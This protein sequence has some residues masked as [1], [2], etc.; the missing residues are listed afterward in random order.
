MWSKVAKLA[1]PAP[2][3]TASSTRP[4][5]SS[6]ASAFVRLVEQLRTLLSS[7]A[8]DARP[9]QGQESAARLLGE[10][11]RTLKAEQGSASS[12]SP[13][14]T[15]TE[16][17]LEEQVF[18]ELVGLVADGEKQGA[19]EELVKWYGRAIVDLEEGWLSHSAVNKPLVKLLRACVNEEGGLMRQ[20]E[21]AVVE[22]MCIVAERIKTRPELLAIFF[23]EKPGSRRQKDLS[24]S[25]AAAMSRPV[26]LTTLSSADENGR[27]SSPTLSQ[28]SASEASTSFAPS[29]TSSAASPRRRSDH[30]FLLFS[31]L[32]RFIH[33]EGEV[34]DYAREG[35]LSLVDVAFGYPALHTPS[36]A[37]PRTTSSSIVSPSSTV[38][39][40]PTSTTAAREAVLAFAEYL[41]DSDFA[42]VLG[43]G[44]G[45]LYGLLPSKLF[46]RT[47]S[48]TAGSAALQDGAGV[49]PVTAAGGMVLGGM[50]ALHSEEGDAEELERQREEEEDRLRAEGYGISGTSEVRDGL[51]GFLKLVEFAQDVLHRSTDGALLAGTGEKHGD[52]HIGEVDEEDDVRQQKLVLNTLTTAVLGA[53]RTLF[54]QNVLYP[55]IL[56]CSETDG[57][58]VAVLS[59]LDA[60][61]EVVQEGTKLEGAVLGFLMAEDEPDL[62]GAGRPP[63]PRQRP[64]NVSTSSTPSAAFLAPQPTASHVKRRKSSALLLIERTAPSSSFH[65]VDPYFA[66]TADGR[67]S[68]R[69]LLLSHVHS[70][71]PSTAAAALKLLQTMLAKHD[72]WA[73]ALLDVTVEEGATA[74]PVAL[75]ETPPAALLED[76]SDED[77]GEEAE[78]VYRSAPGKGRKQ[79]PQLD[80]SSSSDEEFVYPSSESPTT[81]RPPITPRA[82]IPSLPPHPAFSSRSSGTAFPHTPVH[83]AQRLLGTPLPPTPSVTQHLDSL[84]TLLSLVAVI[85]P[86]Y[87]R[88]RARGAAHGSELTNTGFANYLRD[89][90]ASLAGDAGFRRGLLVGP[91][92]PPPIVDERAHQRRRSGLFG[93]RLPVTFSGQDFA[94]APSG[95]KHVLRPSSSKLTAQLLDS[96][97]AFFAHTPD[98]NLALTAVLARMAMSP[99]RGLEG[100]LLPRFPSSD[101]AVDDEPKR[102]TKGEKDSP[103]SDDGDDRS[104]DFE[105]DERGRHDALL[106]PLPSR[107]GS[108]LDGHPSTSPDAPSSATRAALATPAGA[109]TLLSILDALA[110]SVEQYRAQI[111]RFDEFLGERRQ[112]LF[113]AENLAEA[114]GDA[115]GNLGGLSDGGAEE[116]AFGLP[117]VPPRPPVQAPETKKGSSGFASLG[118]GGFFSPR[119]PSHTRSPSTPNVAAFSTPTKPRAHAPSRP[120]QLRRS[121]SDDSLAPNSPPSSS[122]GFATA[123]PSAS[124][125]PPT[126]DGSS[127]PASPFAAHYRQT[128]AITVSPV[129]VNTLRTVRQT[130]NEDDEP[131]E[132]K[133]DGAFDSPTKRLST[134]VRPSSPTRSASSSGF[135]SLT[136]A[137]IA[138]SKPAPPPKPVSLSTILDNCIVLEEFAKELAAIVYVRR[139]VG[140]DQVRFL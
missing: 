47:G 74:F 112:G 33:R 80:D 54:L 44:L 60:L 19:R 90:E 93:A 104:V 58:A 117:A 67:F 57:S 41:L 83:A 108:F 140:V 88:A 22:V 20:E 70:S 4:S 52:S 105:M 53:V 78:F 76:S 66:S 40:A 131:E 100:W 97:A 61:L 56:E 103:R 8:K 62:T 101:C 128:G 125:A 3:R 13:L 99:Y 115:D 82:S 11:L 45:A 107:T 96:L 9:E 113:F 114:L 118:L 89:A 110:R 23:R 7:P 109:D 133:D 119:K 64:S 73:L 81:P 98:V 116:N 29:L 126:Q 77:E 65:T 129:V 111:P 25:L 122:S 43:A 6:D 51:D 16:H 123:R 42:E 15:C 31:Y 50:G 34:G 69:D 14:G 32:L 95:T 130:R 12:T 121:A 72:R 46:V 28:A 36:F 2:R 85:D 27:P 134:P 55:S 75:R 59:Y 71:S 37:L 92:A 127:G 91:S 124:L 35:I 48:A 136:G 38:L 120:S 10:L 87:R 137:G 24:A 39:T 1:S 17:L 26:P 30:D 94:A 102:A 63:P 18:D 135:T 5:P 132:E 86:S 79:K 84:D 21:L 49:E 138:P 139:A 68:L 106:S